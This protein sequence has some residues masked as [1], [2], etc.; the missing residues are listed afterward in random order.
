MKY[1]MNVK[2][3]KEID[4][5][6]IQEVGI[7]ALVLMEK[8][9]EEIA[10]LLGENLTEKEEI[11]AVCGT[12]NNGGDAV[13]AVRIL[14]E[15]GYKTAVCV[16]GDESKASEE[17]KKQLLIARNCGVSMRGKEAI[18]E[19][20]IIID[21]LFGVG[22]SREVTGEYRE[23][24]EQINKEAHRVIA[25]DVPSGINGDNGKVMGV[26]MKA[27]ATV[28]FGYGKLGLYLYP[29]CEYAGKVLI[30]DIGFPKKAEHWVK[31]DCFFYEKEDLDK[32]PQRKA[33]SNKGSYGKLL[34][35]GGAK[36]MS[37]ACILAAKAALRSGAGLVKIVAAEENR[38]IV[39]SCLPEAMFASWEELEKELFW[40]DAVVL[41]P[42]LSQTEESAKIFEI[43]WKQTQLPLVLDADGL[44]LL[45]KLGGMDYSKR[46]NVIF[47]PHLKEMERI[48][49]YLV[50]ELQE[51]FLEIA[52]ACGEK[53]RILVLK[54]ARTVVSDGEQLYLNV[55][56]NHA[57]AKGGSGD[58]LSGIIGGFLVQGADLFTAASLGAFVHGL[59]AE[60]FVETKS[61]Y[62]LM[63]GELTE[64]VKWILP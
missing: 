17:M 44:N 23:V 1:L 37:G 11:L 14:H 6:S 16:I 57:L 55:S 29:G 50:K 62:S 32:L 39:Q 15:K 27:E 7:P 56:G 51:K 12:G 8:A 52:R 59:A 63:A 40:A 45:A 26:A 33:Y 42:G 25:V 41:G 46:S 22:L 64:E 18:R 24:I 38:M 30:K 53:D 60:H 13:A 49:G 5:Y 36:G 54:D 20:N 21:G 3:M 10:R 4:R 2:Q 31:P 34:V 58:V 9:A 19:Y 48:S 47:T 61:A 28:T 43:V 35:V